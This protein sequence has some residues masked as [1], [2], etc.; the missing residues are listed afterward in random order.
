LDLS[1]THVRDPFSAE[2]LPEQESDVGG[3]PSI[4]DDAYAGHSRTP[5]RL[6]GLALAGALVLIVNITSARAPCARYNITVDTVYD[7][8][9]KLTWERLLP[10]SRSFTWGNAAD[11]GTAQNYCDTLQSAGGGWRL[12]TIKELFTIVDVTR[13]TGI[14]PAVFPG[15][16][17]TL[18]DAVYIWSSTPSGNPSEPTFGWAL[19]FGTAYLNDPSTPSTVKCVR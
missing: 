2:V 4:P 11:L 13:L 8:K 5:G 15:D 12:P 17:G 14:D 19:V 3:H 10:A 1:D 16:Y 6:A 9:T 7:T 18:C